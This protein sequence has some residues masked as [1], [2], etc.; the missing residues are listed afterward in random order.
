MAYVTLNVMTKDMGVFGA[1][2]PR[3]LSH[4]GS[5]PACWGQPQAKERLT[6]VSPARRVLILQATAK[7]PAPPRARVD[8][9][10]SA[11]SE[12][13]CVYIERT[14]R[15]AAAG[16]RSANECVVSRQLGRRSSRRQPAASP[17]WRPVGGQV[18]EQGGK[19]EE[20]PEHQQMDLPSG[21]TSEYAEQ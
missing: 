15:A 19:L 9:K 5:P 4:V 3:S 18:A 10:R 8:R 13:V 2:A 20:L 17:A 6:T 1:H 14:G 21:R 7:T 11:R 12:P 16:W